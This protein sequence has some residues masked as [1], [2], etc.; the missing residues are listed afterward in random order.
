MRDVK[1]ID[2]S[3]WTEQFWLNSGGT[4]AKKVLQDNEGQEWFFKC[5]EKKEAKDGKPEKYYRYEFWSEIIAYQLGHAWGLDILRYDPAFRDDQIGCIS[6]NM[7]TDDREQ[8]IEVGRFMTAISDDF[9]PAYNETRNQYTFQ[10]LDKTLNHFDLA[11]YWDHFFQTILFDSVIGNTD[12]HQEN[13]AFIGRST[14]ISKSLDEIERESKEK[15]F[16]KLGWF[17]RNIYNRI[18]DKESNRFNKEGEQLRLSV[19]NISRMAPIYD[20]GSSMAR[21]LNDDMVQ[22]LLSDEARLAKYIDSGKAEIHWNNKK[23]S[24]FDLIL[25]LLNSSYIQEVKKA[26][27]FLSKMDISIVKDIINNIDSSLPENWN[28][29]KIPQSRKDLIFKLVTLR[30]EKLKELI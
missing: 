23:L 30:A 8:L 14:L 20:S 26:G 1:F 24:H 21:E 6:R 3:E 4:R 22:A 5:S 15:G 19:T 28:H 29:Y 27:F 13:W 18:I 12:R 9:S 2:A 11:N 7:I 10:L 25:E 17:F 16:L